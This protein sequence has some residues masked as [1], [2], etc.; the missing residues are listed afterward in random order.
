MPPW[1]ESC[2]NAVAVGPFAITAAFLFLIG[3]CRRWAAAGRE[4]RQVDPASEGE[5]SRSDADGDLEVDLDDEE[6]SV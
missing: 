2:W 6:D 3:R 1:L 5:T 4:W